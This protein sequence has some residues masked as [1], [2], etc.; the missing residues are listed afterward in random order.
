M[1]LPYIHGGGE[2]VA[3]WS[4]NA[5]V[6]LVTMLFPSPL[7]LSFLSGGRRIKKHSHPMCFL[8]RVN[9]TRCTCA[10]CSNG[11]SV[12]KKCDYCEQLRPH[13][14]KTLAYALTHEGFK[15]MEHSPKMVQW[16]EGCSG[17]LDGVYDRL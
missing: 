10:Q 11:L 16:K 4:Q 1:Y 2:Q 3:F 7:S 6:E 8:L 15:D 14:T 17:R 5:P 13:D 9:E 12:I